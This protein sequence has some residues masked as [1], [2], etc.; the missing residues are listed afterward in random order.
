[1]ALVWKR[2][3]DGAG[4]SRDFPGGRWR[5]FFE[6]SV[7]AAEG[8]VERT[9]DRRRVGV[10]FV[11]PRYFETL[12]IRLLTGR[13]FTFQDAGR[14]RVVLINQTMARRYF[15]GVNPVGKRIT[16]DTNSKPG[17]FG[18]NQPYEIVGLVED[19]KTY[20]LRDPPFPMM[21]F[22]MVQETNC[23]ISLNC[24]LREIRFLFP[25]RYGRSYETF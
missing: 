3:G 21:Y 11:A 20:D 25:E 10:T 13:D 4:G 12:G 8:H 18:N 9:E 22:S 17:W 24:T 16:V 19:A 5:H 15:P 7:A 1:V 14:S 23:W 2:P 6:P